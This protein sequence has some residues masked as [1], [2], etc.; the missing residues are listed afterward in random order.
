MM[1]HFGTRQPSVSGQFPS[2]FG[3]TAP[4]DDGGPLTDANMT[5]AWQATVLTVDFGML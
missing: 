1:H 3:D 5:L 2:I 4:L